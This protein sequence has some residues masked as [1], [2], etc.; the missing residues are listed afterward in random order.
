MS[1]SS[2]TDSG[3]SPATAG[4]SPTGGFAGSSGTTGPVACASAR[5][6]QHNAEDGISA[7]NVLRLSLDFSTLASR[8]YIL[9]NNQ[10]PKNISV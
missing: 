4:A 10:V 7:H 3:L 6:L 8:F 2:P 1:S 9:S 5:L